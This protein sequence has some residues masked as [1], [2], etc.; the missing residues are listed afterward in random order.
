MKERKPFWYVK[1]WVDVGG[2]TPLDVHYHEFA[3]YEAA[4]NF[5]DKFTCE[6]TFPQVDLCID[7]D[8]EV[9]KLLMKIYT[10]HGTE[11]WDENDF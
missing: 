2:D 3:T 11:V 7:T 5:F 6:P 9:R 10:S 1:V 4:K 8:D